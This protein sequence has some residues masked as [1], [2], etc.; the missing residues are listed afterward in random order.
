MPHRFRKILRIALIV[1]GFFSVLW[2][3]LAAYISLHKKEL[4]HNITVQLSKS[5]GGTLTI[6]D[7]KPSLLVT[8]PYISVSLH[9]VSLHD[10]MWQHHHHNLLQAE[11]IYL[12]LNP[13]SLL[14]KR[15]RI[16]EISVRNGSFYLFTD[17]NGYT[18]SYMLHKKD[19]A[20]IKNKKQ[21]V[22]NRLS[23]QHMHVLIK[24]DIKNKL[25]EFDVNNVSGEMDY[26]DTGWTIMS[27][28]NTRIKE[29]NFNI[30]KGSFLKDK[31]IKASLK[32]QYL[33]ASHRLLIPPQVLKID[34]APISVK[35][36]F[37]FADK[38]PSFVL[39]F[40]T[41][42]ISYGSATSLV[43]PSI[44]HHLDSFEFVKPVK[45]HAI[46]DGKM[47]YRDTPFVQVY[48]K[49]E[50]NILLTGMGTLD[51]CYMEGYYTNELKPGMGHGD[52]N[53]A[54]NFYNLHAS[55]ADIPFT[56]DTVRVSNLKN[57]YLRCHVVS[58]FSLSAINAITGGETFIFNSGQAKANMYYNGA[59]NRA[60]TNKPS[61]MGTVLIEDA[62][63][64][65]LPRNLNFKNCNALLA[66]NGND[67]YL[68]N[69]SV[70]SG[71]SKLFM[72]GNVKNLLNFYYNAPEKI[73]FDW[74]ITSPMINLNEFSTFFARRKKVK[75]L[76][77]RYKKLN[78]AA[79][80]LDDV[81]DK[82]N[83]HMAL[84][85]SKMVYRKFAAGNINADMFMDEDGIH[86]QYI[87]LNHAGGT[88]SGK[89]DIVERG[90]G[91]KFDVNAVVNK[92]NVDQLF[93]AFDEFGQEAV[94]HTNIKGLLSANVNISGLLS[95]KSVI[96]PNSIEGKVK[97]NL[98]NGAL[99]H[100]EP[101]EKISKYVFKRRNL[102]N[103]TFSKVSS[104]FNI[105]NNKIHISPMLVRSSAINFQ[106]EGVYAPPKNT[107]ISIVLP[108][109]KPDKEDINAEDASLEQNWKKG[110]V[111]Y[112]KA[113]DGETGK[114]KIGWDRERGF[115]KKEKRKKRNRD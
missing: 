35:A 109:G 15:P 28:I 40:S 87:N 3:V 38:V 85:V 72:E 24:D 25:F 105:R 68:N 57:P 78:R 73:V 12:Q 65:Y 91:K 27:D 113:T 80:Q 110:L 48:W 76:T 19:T 17:R 42:G 37:S 44:A 31:L 100:F 56:A 53:S 41:N 69:I 106:V 94:D 13:F 14:R 46:I 39:D 103:I 99:I 75:S 51:N 86:L 59:I 47:K 49:A 77:T 102:S 23:M 70:Q 64:A 71:Q 55:W 111:L 20:T 45:L 29:C 101:L 34:D 60:D 66:F 97:F 92:V 54:L 90:D 18:N 26:N 50:N 98:E 61:V 7:M 115:I 30:E 10:S 104:E 93:N 1:T 36:A 88:L 95:D 43:S 62:A 89:A 82:S 4:L 79:H 5:I 112:L 84:H 33:Y 96:V 32:L 16:H 22:F 21:A 11:R 63:M 74:K 114:M 9:N 81:L 107:D 2:V 8:F 52:N 108:L 58:T 6:E 83:V 67:L